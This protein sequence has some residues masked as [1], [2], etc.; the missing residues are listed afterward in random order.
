MRVYGDPSEAPDDAVEVAIEMGG[1]VDA[2]TVLDVMHEQQVAEA[3]AYKDR[4]RRL[5]A[6]RCAGV[7]NECYGEIDPDDG[8]EFGEASCE[9]YH[10]GCSS[11]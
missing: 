8:I 9:T 4:V 3:R 11:D 7:C 5:K 2:Q 1:D 6:T 10:P